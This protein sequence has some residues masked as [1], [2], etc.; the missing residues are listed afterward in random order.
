MTFHRIGKNQAKMNVTV[1]AT[2]GGAWKPATLLQWIEPGLKNGRK[3]I[4]VSGSMDKMPSTVAKAAPSLM[5]NQA[6]IKIASSSAKQT[7]TIVIPIGAP[8]VVPTGEIRW[9]GLKP[10]STAR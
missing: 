7:R 3:I 10:N 2:C 5:P 6:G 9:P 1:T 8:Q 4:A